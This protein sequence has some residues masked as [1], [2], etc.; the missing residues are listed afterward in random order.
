MKS[1][2]GALRGKR[3]SGVIGDFIQFLCEFF[4]AVRGGEFNS[5][6]DDKWGKCGTI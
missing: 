5:R 3:V 6:V 2:G 1:C 4:Y